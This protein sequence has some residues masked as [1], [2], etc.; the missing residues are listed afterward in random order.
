MSQS[1]SSYRAKWAV[2][3]LWGN[4]SRWKPSGGILFIQAGEIRD[5]RW[6]DQCCSGRLKLNIF[7]L[8]TILVYVLWWVLGVGVIMMITVNNIR[9]SSIFRHFFCHYPCKIYIFTTARLD[10]DNVGLQDNNPTDRLGRPAILVFGLRYYRDI[11]W[12]IVREKQLMQ[13]RIAL[14]ATVLKND[15]RKCGVEY[16]QGHTIHWKRST[17]L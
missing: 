6:W 17:C 3:L 14:R 4:I 15:Q 5:D 13:F 2:G 9:V 11:F 8:N 7:I 12:D 10:Q 1:D 16:R